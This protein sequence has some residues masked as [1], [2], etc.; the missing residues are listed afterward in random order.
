MSRIFG[1]ISGVYPGQSF[2]SRKELSKA[3]VHRPPQ[4]G[5]SGAENEGA[6][7]I[8]LSGGYADDEDHGDSLVYTGHGGRD[9]VS[10]AQVAH[11]TL[12]KGNRALA[13]SLTLGLP[14]RVIRG[15]QAHSQ[16]SPPEGYRYD[17]LFMVRDFWKECGSAGFDVWRF[18]LILMEEDRHGS[19]TVKEDR[20]GSESKPPRRRVGE[21]SRIIRDT[22]LSRMIKEL[23]DFHCQVCGFRFEGPAGPYS[24]A[25]H[26][27]PLGRPHRGPDTQSN[28]L[29]LCPNHH[30]MFDY[31]GFAIS[32][33][34]ELIGIPG[35]LS[36]HPEHY[37]NLEFIRYHRSSYGSLLGEEG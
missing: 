9:P 24:E 12:S 20:A 2:L 15:Y 17:G 34:F 14:V 22:R 19:S 16:Y 31:G 30:V 1:H 7:S 37:I 29:C 18:R 5:I 4:A 10:G 13:R 6:D 3:G 33:S 36:V 32:D 23:Y 8:V 25:A 21:V 27:K 28:L 11:Q 35:K 26:I